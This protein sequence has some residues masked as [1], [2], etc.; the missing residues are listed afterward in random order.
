MTHRA[1]PPAEST[2]IDLSALAAVTAMRNGELK[3]EHYARALLDQAGRMAHLNAFRVLDPVRVLEDARAADRLRHSGANVGA[4]HGL[5]IPVKDSIDS[6]ALP[7]SNGT[8]TLRDFVPRQDAEVLTRLFAAGAIL[9]GKTNLHELSYGW[10][11][12]NE[13]FG[14]VRNPYDIARTPGGS[15]GGSGAAVAARIAPLALAEDT[16]G[17]IRVP[18]GMCGLAGL[19]PS[20]GRYPNGGILAQSDDRF[21]QVGPLARTVE[22]LVLFDSVMAGRP[23]HLPMRPI[24]RARIGIA[25]VPM[26]TELDSEVAR[27]SEEGFDRLR[28]AGAT[29]VDAP[30]PPAAREAMEAVLTVIAFETVPVFKAFLQTQCPAL[31][32]EEMLNGTGASVR[33]ELQSY[34]LPPGRPS[35]QAYRAALLQLEH[36]RAEMRQHFAVQGIEALAF[37]SIMVLPPLIG[38]E[39]EVTSDGRQVPLTLAMARNT[40]LGTAARMASLVL[41]VGWSTGGLPIGLEFAALE[42]EDTALLALG[43][44]LERTL[45]FAARPVCRPA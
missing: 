29:L 35:P 31:S 45:A 13:A 17:S 9:M 20:Y 33:A 1:E 25:R 27:V 42:G 4:L 18:A 10:T 11:S 5:P 14:A 21:D 3:A 19:R 16:L 8:R 22:D 37:P 28:S 6:K 26:M 43:L 2:L 15:S 41:P 12:N 7:T 44:S 32:F 40:A 23:Q 36:I 30:L 24:S 38:E 39:V 34:A